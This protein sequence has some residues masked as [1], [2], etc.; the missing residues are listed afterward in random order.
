MRNYPFHPVTLKDQFKFNASI[1]AKITLMNTFVARKSFSFLLLF[2]SVLISNSVLAIAPEP[3]IP[4]LSFTSSPGACNEI[5]LAFI[6]GDGSRRLIIGSIG[7]PVS[8]F[9]VDGTSYSGGSL[10]GTGTNL[11]GGNYVVYNGS[12]T[13]ATI[14]GLDGGSQYYFAIFEFNGVGVNA[15][16]L[17]SGY[18]ETDAIATGIS[19]TVL[20]STG[21]ICYGDS[22]TLTASGATTYQWTPSS[23]LSS[24]TDPEVV[25]HPTTTT[26]YTVTGTDTSGCQDQK[27]LN[28]VVNQLPNV[29][30]SNQA[31]V[32]QNAGTV[33]LSGGVPIGGDYFG[34]GIS[35]NNFD[36]VVAGI[37]THNITYIYTDAHGCTDSSSTTI[38]VLAA[39]SVTFSTVPSVCTGHGPVT[40]SQGSPAGGSYYGTGVTVGTTFNPS[41]AGIGTFAL[42]YVY[43]SG[44]CSDT[45]TSSITVNPL[46]T[47]SFATLTPVC[48]NTPSFTLSGGNPTGGNYTGT[49]VSANHFDPI[50]TGSGFYLITYTYTDS[51][52]C[53]SS[54]TS[55]QTVNTIPTVTLTPFNSVCSNTGPVA[56]SGGN[57]A[58]GVYSGTAVSGTTFYTGIAG[59]GAHQITY[60]YVDGNQCGS[61]ATQT[62][63]VNPIP[64]PNLGPDTTICMNE[65]VLLTAG[66]SYATYQWSTGASSSSILFDSTGFGVG[67]VRVTLRVTNQFGCANRDTIFVTIASCTGID[68]WDAQSFEA[69]P[70]PFTSNLIIEGESDFQYTLYDMN[71]K[72][73]TTG[74]SENHQVKMNEDLPAGIY[75]L[76]VNLGDGR[77]LSKRL[78]KE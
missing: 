7:S 14:T 75:L 25:A 30:I 71:G 32:C 67:T 52:G 51:N 22:V 61:S 15:N 56:L 41:I 65:A 40:L 62:L 50:A 54:D 24:A 69:Y 66:N 37:G 11:G 43:S 28:V 17:I 70:N 72:L 48:T 46:P 12:G 18:L 64:T 49:G 58:G 4:T 19:M 77:R 26:T 34:T 3:T 21:D 53:V 74:H 33:H 23:G 29:T 47:V 55:L 59:A 31:D 8:E 42:S 5:N 38:D 73:I 20:S 27:T 2:F 39:P 68:E 6:P 10:Y 63:T 13:S 16:Y 57:P 1:V 78:M 60:T 44:G 45:A 76:M 36:P 35:S 9:P